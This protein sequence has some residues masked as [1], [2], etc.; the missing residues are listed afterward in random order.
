MFNAQVSFHEKCTSHH[1]ESQ[2]DPSLMYRMNEGFAKRVF[3]TNARYSTQQISAENVNP[4][5]FGITN[6]SCILKCVIEV[7]CVGGI[8]AHLFP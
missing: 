3:K 4:S 5:S 1:F 6:N 7:F 8:E 2:H